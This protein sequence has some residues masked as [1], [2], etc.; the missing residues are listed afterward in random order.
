MLETQTT[1]ILRFC[2][3]ERTVTRTLQSDLFLG[4]CLDILPSLPDKSINTICTDPPFFIPATQYVSRE[5]DRW[6]NKFSDLLIMKNFFD[7]LA[8]EFSRLLKPD[9]HIL[10]FCDSVSYPIFF[11]SFYPLFDLTRCLVWSKGKIGMGQSA[12]RHSFEL[13]LHSCNASAFYSHLSGQDVLVCP[14]VPTPERLHPAQKP[15]K[16]L[17]DLLKD[18]TPEN[19]VVLD[20]F[21]GSASTLVAAKELGL[22]YIGVEADEPNFEIGKKRL[23]TIHTLDMPFILSDVKP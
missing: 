9:G 19:G 22:N 7:Q 18:C 2:E 14:V 10:I 1:S 3:I 5:Q 20:S 15:V 17:K 12:W 4:D 21:F 16:L 23:E 8:K 11:Q 13:I 6:K